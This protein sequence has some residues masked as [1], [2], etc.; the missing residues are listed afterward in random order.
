MI[1]YA[2]NTGLWSHSPDRE[3]FIKNCVTIYKQAE[4]NL[5]K[6]NKAQ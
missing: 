6:P 2:S 5:P 3:Y 4:K 1:K